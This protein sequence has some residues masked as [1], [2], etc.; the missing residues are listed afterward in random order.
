MN[1]ASGL[2]ARAPTWSGA[3]CTHRPSILGGLRYA[4]PTDYCTTPAECWQPKEERNE[5]TIKH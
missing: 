4:D 5:L 1:A 2:V 3:S